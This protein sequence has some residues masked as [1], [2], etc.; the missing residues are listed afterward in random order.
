MTASRDREGMSVVDITKLLVLWAC[1]EVV[2]VAVL[3]VFLV[4]GTPQQLKLR[5]M[6]FACLVVLWV[7][8]AAFRH[9]FWIQ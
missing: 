1:L 8:K 9:H 6:V 7:V 4:R 2:V 5:R 3:V